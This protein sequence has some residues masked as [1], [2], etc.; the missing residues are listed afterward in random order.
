MSTLDPHALNIGLSWSAHGIGTCDLSHFL[1]EHLQAERFRLASFNLQ[2]P[3][4]KTYELRRQGTSASDLHNSPRVAL[5][6]LEI[7]PLDV[8]CHLVYPLRDALASLCL[9]N[10][11]GGHVSERT[12]EHALIPCHADETGVFPCTY[13]IAEAEKDLQSCKS[14]H[15]LV[16]WAAKDEASFSDLRWFRAK[17]QERRDI[18]RAHLLVH[19]SARCLCA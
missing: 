3:Y 8:C 15:H 5:M 4:R 18:E 6:C 19:A 14:A 1:M 2:R 12:S 10:I 11:M 16:W 9:P 17:F 13:E 7:V